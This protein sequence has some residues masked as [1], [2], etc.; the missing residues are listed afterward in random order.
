MVPDLQCALICEDVRLEVAGGNTLVGVINTIP[1]PQLPIRLMKICVFTRWCS[2]EGSFDQTTRVLA[3][4]ES[5][6]S[7]T[8]TEFHLASEENH[9]TNVAV[10]GGVEFTEEGAYPVEIYL[11][12]ELILRFPLQVVVANNS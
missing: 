1:A 5:V 11:N 4:D 12:E 7:Q 2:G 3:L 10:F 6:L 9:A 8:K